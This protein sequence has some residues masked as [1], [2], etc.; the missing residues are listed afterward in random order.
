[1]YRE[2]DI[3]SRDETMAAAHGVQIAEGQTNRTEGSIVEAKVPPAPLFFLRPA[4][5]ELVVVMPE[6]RPAFLREVQ[7]VDDFIGRM[8]RT[9]SESQIVQDELMRL[10]H[11]AEGN[12]QSDPL[13]RQLDKLLAEEAS[14]RKAAHEALDGITLNPGADLIELLPLSTRT[15]PQGLPLGKKFTYVRSTKVENHWRAYKLS[16]ADKPQLKS[17][18]TYDKKNGWELDEKKLSKSLRDTGQDVLKKLNKLE[19]PKIT[20]QLAEVEAEWS[21]EFVRAFNN[22]THFH[23]PDE[24]NDMVQ[25]GGGARVLRAFAGASGALEG[26]FEGSFDEM[27]KGKL[28]T[29]KAALKGKAE[30]ALM[31]AEGQVDFKLFLPHSRGLG[32]YVLPVFKHNKNG[33]T[34]VDWYSLGNIRFAFEFGANGSV[35]AS[36]LAEGGVELEFDPG[37]V[38]QLKG[39]GMKRKA[40]DVRARSLNV[41]DKKD[42][43]AK[44][45]AD[46][47]AELSAFAGASAEGS[48]K[49]AIQWQKPA[50]KQFGDFAM[51]EP[52]IAGLAGIGGSAAFGIGYSAK[53]KKFRMVAKLSG[54]VGL[55]LSGKI[56]AE[57]GIGEI[58]EFAC[59]F[60]YQVVAAGDQN[61][62]YFMPGAHETFSAMYTLAIL[63]RKA[64]GNYLGRE[65]REMQIYLGTWIAK[66]GEAFVK[67]VNASDEMLLTA[68]A[69][70]KGYLL[71]QLRLLDRK[72]DAF[73]DEFDETWRELKRNVK[74]ALDSL[75]GAVYLQAELENVYQ[76]ATVDFSKRADTREVEAFVNRTVDDDERMASLKRDLKDVPVVGFELARNDTLTYRLQHGVHAAWKDN[77]SWPGDSAFA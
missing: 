4:T 2:T 71:E 63:E 31:L 66:N 20:N 12:A 26:N 68:S 54:C 67:A 14:A 60:R 11:T 51:I 41:K 1:M 36:V 5:G 22:D 7:S 57:V 16:G 65:F 10:P 49:G 33:E 23:S 35:G 29:V 50:S 59:W 19:T 42:A 32:L 34:A 21:P 56:G 72:L 61:L 75:L 45:G 43:K 47:E 69:N 27:L 25:Y 70:V 17:F 77:V 37:G 76:Y 28:P 13:M 8:M 53:D 24:E 64:L 3:S 44:A 73:K 18:L 58:A 74:E 48:V 15:N 46:V 9:R 62:K 52:K 6:D 39:R 38:Q 30:G 40:S 55:G